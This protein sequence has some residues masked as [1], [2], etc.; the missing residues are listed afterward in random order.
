MSNMERREESIRAW[1]DRKTRHARM[2][3]GIGA[4]AILVFA[5]IFFLLAPSWLNLKLQVFNGAV[6]IPFFGGLWLAAFII[7]WLVPMREVGFRSQEVMEKMMDATEA[8]RERADRLMGRFEK[9]M[10]QI[11]DG[12]HPIVRRVEKSFK[13]ESRRLRE[14]IRA[15]RADAEEELENALAEGEAEA[16]MIEEGGEGG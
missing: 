10:D 3:L 14:E 12:D 4:A 2:G 9:L 15:S 11:E 5:V 13:D 6:T 8:G 16:T 1:Y 7:I